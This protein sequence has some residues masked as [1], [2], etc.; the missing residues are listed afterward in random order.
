MLDEGADAVWNPASSSSLKSSGVICS[1]STITSAS[2][3][4]MASAASSA[5]EHT[6][7]IKYRKPGF[8]PQ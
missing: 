3:A 2:P 4:F 5:L 1:E 7:V 8:S 6:I